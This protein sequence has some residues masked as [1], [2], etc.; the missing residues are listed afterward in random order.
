M[1]AWSSMYLDNGQA[2]INNKAREGITYQISIV[3]VSS[4]RVI[5]DECQVR[6][7]DANGNLCCEVGEGEFQGND[8]MANCGNDVVTQYTIIQEDQGQGGSILKK[9]FYPRIKFYLFLNIYIYYCSIY[10]TIVTESR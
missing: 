5:G 2:S 8:F 7:M 1:E 10:I 3:G 6:F 9:V 4:A